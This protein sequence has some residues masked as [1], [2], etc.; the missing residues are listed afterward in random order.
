MSQAVPTHTPTR[1]SA[2]GFSIAALAAGL[3]V[4]ALAN[5]ANPDA[6]LVD[7][8]KTMERQWGVTEVIAEEMHHQPPGITAQSRES[9]RQMGNAM[10]DWW[11]TV[12]QIID[13]PAHSAIGI[14][15]K[16][17]AMQRMMECMTFDERNRTNAE[18]LLDADPNDRMAWSL[19]TDILAGSASA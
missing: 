6:K 1:R 8:L 3:T 13:T 12:E 18:Q 15:A 14:R 9:E 4:P 2:L 7:L 11:D 19:A 16:A 17:R 10:D 5:A